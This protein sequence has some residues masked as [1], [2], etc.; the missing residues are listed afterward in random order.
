MRGSRRAA[1]LESGPAKTIG[2][3]P[4]AMVHP[5]DGILERGRAPGSGVQLPGDG[6]NARPKLRRRDGEIP[7]GTKSSN[8]RKMRCSSHDS[9][10]RSLSRSMI[11]P[12]AAPPP[13]CAPISGGLRSRIPRGKGG[14]TPANPGLD[15]IPFPSRRRERLQVTHRSYLSVQSHKKIPRPLLEGSIGS[16]VADN[17]GEQSCLGS[18]GLGRSG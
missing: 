13:T 8:T 15:G 1:E 9:R 14:A 7:P 10:H 4:D 11:E 5:S 18:S 16:T 6:P 2:G 3:V 12:A 17:G